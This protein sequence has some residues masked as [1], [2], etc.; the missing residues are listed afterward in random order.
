LISS[1]STVRTIGHILKA[2][3]ATFG[4]WTAGVAGRAGQAPATRPDAVAPGA[5]EPRRR[6]E[7]VFG[8]DWQMV[9]EPVL[10]RM[11][12][13]PDALSLHVRAATQIDAAEHAL[14]RIL[15]DCANVGCRI[16]TPTLEPVRQLARERGAARPAQKSLAA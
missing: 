6:R 9:T 10:K 5:R 14:N 7:A 12:R 15:A 2:V 11:R 3:P 13:A 16:G 8:R 1:G 4:G